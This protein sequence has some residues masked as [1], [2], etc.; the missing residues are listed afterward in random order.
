MDRQEKNSFIQEPDEDLLLAYIRGKVSHEDAERIERWLQNNEANEKIV[1]QIASLY[2][3]QRRKQR[4][5]QRNPLQAF[6]KAQSQINARMGKRRMIHWAVAAACISGIVI[7]STLISYLRDPFKV[8]QQ[9]QVITVQS[10]SG[11]RSK[12]NLPD[13]TIVYLNSGSKLSY[14]VPFDAAE[15][16][17]NLTGEAYFNVAHDSERPFIADAFD[18]KFRVKVLGTE[19]NMQAFENKTDASVVLVSGRVNILAKGSDNK[20]YEQILSPSEKIAY[21]ILTGKMNVEK[22]VPQYEIAW[23]EGRLM[24]K[25]SSLSEVLKKLSYFYNVKFEVKNPTISN[26]RFTG[27]FENRQLVQVLDYLQ[28]SSDIKYHIKQETEDDSQGVK[29]TVVTLQ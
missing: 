3:A 29:Q 12:F 10:N 22:V 1:L 23:I 5:E 28:I 20:V 18:G 26:Y 13:G 25:N 7:L 4:I 14:S 21:N 8:P 17:V 6:N 9:E 19:F 11:M 16:H 27:T 15:R 24:F 2:F